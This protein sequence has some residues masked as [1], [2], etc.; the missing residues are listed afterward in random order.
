LYQGELLFPQ[1]H[2]LL[3]DKGYQMIS[4][5]PGFSDSN[6]GQVLQVEGVFCRKQGQLSGKSGSGF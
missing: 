2:Q 3:A 1:M 4:I 6:S 5:D